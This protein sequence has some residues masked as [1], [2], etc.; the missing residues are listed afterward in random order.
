MNSKLITSKVIVYLMLLFAF[1]STGCNYSIKTDSIAAKLF[2]YANDNNSS[3]LK[4]QDYFPRKPIKKYFSGG[5]ENG[6]F[7]HT[8]DKF[9]GVDVKVLTPAGTFYTV[10]VTIKYRDSEL[11]S[12]F[13]YAKD[14]GLVKSSMISDKGLSI[15]D[16]LIKLE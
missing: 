5:F 9:Q 8:F 7:T 15:D 3:K 12:K 6:G 2:D 16:L 4:I 14:L 13:Y 1:S 11:I 10:E